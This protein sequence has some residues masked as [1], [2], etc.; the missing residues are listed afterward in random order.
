M[1]ARAPARRGVNNGTLAKVKIIGSSFIPLDHL[2][3]NEHNPR[4]HY[5]FSPDNTH[6]LE[7]ADSLK[8][9]GQHN[10]IKVYE[11]ADSPGHFKLV[12]GHRRLYSARLVGEEGLECQLI[13][14]PATLAEELDWL[15]SEDAGKKAWGPFSDLRYAKALADAH[16]YVAM[17]C[18]EV[19]AKTGFSLTQLTKGRKMFSLHDAIWSHVRKW[20]EYQYTKELSEEAAANFDLDFAVQSGIKI[21][22]FSPDKAAWTW[23]IFCSLKANCAPIIPKTMSDFDLQLRIAQ[24]ASR[25][26]LRDLQKFKVT[27][28]GMGHAASAPPGGLAQIASLLEDRNHTRAVRDVVRTTRNTYAVKLALTTD[29]VE[30]LA[31]ALK[32]LE[33]H[34]DQLGSDTELLERAAHALLRLQFRVERLER[35]ISAKKRDTKKTEGAA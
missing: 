29:K 32:L 15:G 8:M 12:Q 35:R 28:D 14:P 18:V 23:D 20:E 10:A 4:E 19:V 33:D 30:R 22:D 9:S 6:I 21:S 7:L 11:M 2:H 1:A 3:E 27:I 26:T 31:T 25:T 16:G 34:A 24:L 17:D 13:R 5:Q